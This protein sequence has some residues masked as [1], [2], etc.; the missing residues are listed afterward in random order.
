VRRPDWADLIFIGLGLLAVIIIISLDITY[1][2]NRIDDLE[3]RITA[4]ETI[5]IEMVAPPE[6][7]SP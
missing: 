6:G 2:G 7:V 1:N 3:Q 5:R 4:V